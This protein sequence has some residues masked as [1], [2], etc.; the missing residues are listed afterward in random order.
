MPF[1]KVGPNKYKSPGGKTFTAAQI[2]LYYANN[3]SFPKKKRKSRKSL[4]PG[5]NMSEWQFV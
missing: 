2:K 4:A 5:G 3:Q 1:H